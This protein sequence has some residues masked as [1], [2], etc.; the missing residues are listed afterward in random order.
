M[1]SAARRLDDL[2]EKYGFS[3]EIWDADPAFVVDLINLAVD[4][5]RERDDLAIE[6]KGEK[7]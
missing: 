2:F 7:T 4:I 3:L 5:G 1:L 6:L